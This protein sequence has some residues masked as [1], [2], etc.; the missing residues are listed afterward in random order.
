M[1]RLERWLV[2]SKMVETLD[3]ETLRNVLDLGG[4]IGGGWCEVH[5]HICVNSQNTEKIRELLAARGYT[6]SAA[7]ESRI[8]HPERLAGH[9][10]SSEK[11]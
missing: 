4:K 7:S 8:C 3:K 1:P 10:S 9:E 6:V 5:Q 2:V 11:A